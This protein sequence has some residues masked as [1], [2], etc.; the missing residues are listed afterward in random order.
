MDN[1][2]HHPPGVPRVE[3]PRA[4]GQFHLAGGRRLGYAEFGDPEGPVVLWFHGTLGAR[5]QFLAKGRRAAERLGLRVI[6]IE[7]PG[8]GLSD[9]HRYTSVSEW[10][11]DMAQVV[12]TLGADQI[13]VVGMSGGGPYALACGALPPLVDRVAA[14]GVLD[15]TVPAVGPEATRAGATE[16]ARRFGPILTQLRRPLAVIATI[17][18]A[19][20]IPFAHYA[21]R[22]YMRMWPEVDRKVLD[23][24]EVEAIF[25]DDMVNAFRGRCL[26]MVDDARLLGRDWGFRLV[27]VKVP[28]RWWHGE[29]DHVVPIAGVHTAITRLQDAE[30]TVRSESHL[31]GFAMTEDVLEHMREKLVSGSGASDLEVAQ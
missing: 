24:P 22:V 13:G 7:R 12:D 28:V 27:D 15:G 2:L 21:Y 3:K 6:V 18:L 25:V 14:V 29:T 20:L 11:A 8:T 23:D 17:L 30:L 4:E 16:I 9:S 10:V 19:P 5:R 31:G 26:A 1:P